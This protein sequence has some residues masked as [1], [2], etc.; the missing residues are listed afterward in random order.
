MTKHRNRQLSVQSQQSGRLIAGKAEFFAGPLPPPE[1]LEKYDQVVSGAASRIMD[2]AESQTA[3]RQKLE[4]RVITWDII[5][6]VVGLV[7]AFLIAGGGAYLGYDLIQR[8]L[9]VEG[10]VFAAAPIAAIVGS[11]IYGTQSRRKEREHRRDQ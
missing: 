5:K 7:F 2:S 4:S 10:S 1:V 11:L 8:G 6:S 3:H 9:R